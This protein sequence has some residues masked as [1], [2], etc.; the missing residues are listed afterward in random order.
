MTNIG[1]WQVISIISRL[2]ALILGVV[3]S[4][5]ITRILTVAEFGIIGIVGAVGAMFGIAQ[6]F[7]LASGT[8]RE[9]SSAPKE[10]TFK[11]FLSSLILKYI[12]VLPVALALFL[13]APYITRN[14][15]KLDEIAFP[16]RLY[17]AV[18]L[19]QGAQGILNSVIAG[20]QRFRR[21]FLYQVAIAGVSLFLYIPLVYF[22]KVDGYFM[23]LLLFN[24]VSTITLSILALAPLRGYLKLPTK[25]ELGHSFKNILLLSLGIYAAKILYT[26]WFKF[27]QITLGYFEALE[28]VGVFSFAV[29][30]SSK[31]QTISDALTDVNLPIFS[32]EFSTNLEGFKQK[33]IGNFKKIFAVI[34]VLTMSASFFAKDVIILA[35]GHKYDASIPLILPLVFSFAFY[36]YLNLLKSSVLVPAKMIFELIGSYAVLFVVTSASYFLMV[37]SFG[38]LMAMSYAMLFGSALGFASAFLLIHNKLKFDILNSRSVGL[39][40]KLLLLIPFNFLA[41]SLPLKLAIFACYT[42]VIVSTFKS[43]NIFN[44]GEVLKR[45]KK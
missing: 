6:H 30:F 22:Y 7:G 9:I 12:I 40:I 34:L 5:V 33:F 25:S 26:A 4:I 35:V 1:R 2:M 37:L 15:Y 41:I 11:I 10:E 14:I 39:T 17:S 42:L 38:S 36:S 8:T 29:L 24:A 21:L 19:V 27:G 32:K 28:V 45:L 16:L 3:Q 31:L 20:L 13:F 18:L 43:E 44:V 23:A